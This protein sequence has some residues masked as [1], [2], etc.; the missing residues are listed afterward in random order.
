[1]IR[2]CPSPKTFIKHRESFAENLEKLMV[3]DYFEEDDQHS[4]QKMIDDMVI[5]GDYFIIYRTYSFLWN[6]M[7]IQERPRLNLSRI[8][9]SISL[10]VFGDKTLPP[11]TVTRKCWRGWKSAQISK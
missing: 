9:S 3:E 11:C 6:R 1:M 2:L 10:K 4:K 5:W 7:K 8:T